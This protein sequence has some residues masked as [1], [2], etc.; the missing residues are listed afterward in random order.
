MVLA[1]RGPH[2][3]SLLWLA[4][5]ALVAAVV[6]LQVSRLGTSRLGTYDDALLAAIAKNNAAR[7]GYASG[8]PRLRPFDPVGAGVGPALL[9]PA[10][11]L[12]KLF[13][14]RYWV[15]GFT[16]I[17]AVWLLAL[18]VARHVR[19]MATPGNRFAVFLIISLAAMLLFSLDDDSEWLFAR[20]Y[21]LFGELPAALEVALGV[22]LWLRADERLSFAGLAGLLWGI[23]IETKL[24]SILCVSPVLALGVACLARKAS[25][26][27]LTCGIFALAGM[28]LPF[29]GVEIWKAVLIGG[30]TPYLALHQD[31]MAWIMGAGSGGH[32][33]AANSHVAS[34]LGSR[35][36][37]NGP[38]LLHYLGGVLPT[39]GL[40]LLATVLLT[41]LRQVF[42]PERW[43]PAPRA[44]LVAALLTVGFVVH[45]GWWLLISPTGWT[46]H[47]LQGLWYLSIAAGV[48]I[49]GTPAQWS[50]W[51]AGI[52]LTVVLAPRLTFAAELTPRFRRQP[53][54]IEQLAVRDVIAEQQT[55]GWRHLGC[56]WWVARDMEYLLPRSGNF[57]NCFEVPDTSFGTG[58]LILV[59]NKEVWNWE[60]DARLDRFAAACEQHI[61]EETAHYILSKCTIGP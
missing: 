8:Y 53:S 30:I 5:S 12:I 57:D 26:S 15:P 1:R 27:A 18:A 24:V 2:W 23:A 49:A 29:V 56:G 3:A 25:L 45:L 46:N 6:T 32:E 59:R 33:L 38:V 9:L 39:L 35:L 50:R 40:L 47:L 36:N 54:L 52:A 4:T 34:Y 37:T 10:S 31:E 20:W 51:T 42:K 61:L 7:Q 41:G 17:L 55:H 44:Q 16:T 22:L 11:G 21:A 58:N 60:K 14:N 19:R 28:A 13:G 43:V 48:A